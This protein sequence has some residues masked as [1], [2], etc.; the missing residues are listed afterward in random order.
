MESTET[1]ETLAD[2]RERFLAYV[3]Q[4]VADPELAEDVVQTSLLKAAESLGSLRS[5][6]SLMPWFYAILR[7][8][9][10]DAYRT[11][12]RGLEVAMA[13]DFDAEEEEEVHAA[14]CECLAMLVPTLRTEYA[15]LIEGLDLRG[16]PSDGMA[17]RLGVTSNNL[18]V[19]H[20]RA[21]RALR[22]RL[23]ETCRVCAEHHCLDCTCRED[24]GRA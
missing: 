22:R 17:E 16:E 6:D 13:N 10:T 4:R 24:A 11:R 21:R 9:I 15:T 12:A 8:A 23:E 20:H 3:R 7:N 5:Q 19:R 18:K 1:I 14:L 2:F